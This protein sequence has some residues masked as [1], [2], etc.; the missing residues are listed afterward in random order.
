MILRKQTQS[1][2]ETQ[3]EK[4]DTPEYYAAMR[5]RQI[6]CEGNL[7][8]QKANHNLKRVRTRG[9]GKA[10]MHCLLSA[11]ALNLK[12]MV[13]LLTRRPR[14]RK[15]CLF[16]GRYAQNA[17]LSLLFWSLSTAPFLTT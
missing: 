3:C 6:W 7:S 2:Y 13:K 14:L 5:L 4:N 17:Y 9:L 11:T 12:R 8:H 1:A 16:V 10:F 15:I